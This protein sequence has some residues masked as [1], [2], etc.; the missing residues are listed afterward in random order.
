[1]KIWKRNMVVAVIMLF[2]CAAVY[3]NWSYNQEVEAGTE[4][5]PAASCWERL[6]WWRVPATIHCWKPR[7][8]KSARVPRDKPVISL[9]PGSTV[10]R[11][12]IQLCPYFRM[13]PRTRQL[14]RS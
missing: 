10:S 1:M 9:Q 6:L 3:L 4:S 13:P 5:R 14:T 12:V 11:H 8:R 7:V 2:V